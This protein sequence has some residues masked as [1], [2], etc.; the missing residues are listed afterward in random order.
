MRSKRLQKQ[1][2]AQ[3][4]YFLNETEEKRQKRLQ[5]KKDYMRK[6]LAQNKLNQ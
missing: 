4:E 1:N 5:S 2:K 3:Q 6:K